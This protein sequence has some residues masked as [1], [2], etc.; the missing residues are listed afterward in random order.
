MGPA[1]DAVYTIA[2]ALVGQTEV[3]GATIAQGMTGLAT[4]TQA[5][6][7]DASGVI[8]PCFTV[9]DHAR[10]L[11]NNMG[12]ILQHKKVTEIGTFGRLEWDSQG[13]K[14]SGLIEMWC[15]NGGGP[16]PSFAS[17]GLTYDIKA[18]VPMGTYVA[19]G[20]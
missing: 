17:S 13:A 10:T 15:I 4:N 19:C 3:T 8:S 18:Q 6:A 9:T 12:S 11:Y 20:P 1:Y 2:L 5:C 14:S 7:Y 16:K